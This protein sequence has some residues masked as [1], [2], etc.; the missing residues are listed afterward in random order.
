MKSTHA[1]QYIVGATLGFWAAVVSVSCAPQPAAAQT[2]GLHTISAH[3]SGGMNNFNPGAF[4]RSAD[5]YTL[6]GYWNSERRLSL[7]AGRSFTV[8]SHGPLSADITLGAITGYRAAPVLPLAVPS[9]AWRYAP[10][11]AV[12]LA[13]IPPLPIKGASAVAHLIFEKEL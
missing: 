7:Y 4:I 3:A 2:L 8:A 9:L 11:S 13:V 5:G 1:R 6:G 12:R 10:R